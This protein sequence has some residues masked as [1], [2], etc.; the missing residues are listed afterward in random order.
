M[1]PTEELARQRQK[2]MMTSATE[3]RQVLLARA[4]GRATRR[5]RRAER[6][7]VLSRLEV[8]RLRGELS[9]SQEP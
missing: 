2:Q 4:L 6:R 9:A 8:T 7:A 5:A 3:V 1:Y